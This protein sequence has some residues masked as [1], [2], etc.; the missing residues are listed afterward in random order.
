MLVTA[1]LTWQASAMSH[2]KPEEPTKLALDAIQEAK[3][4]FLANA[5]P[6]SSSRAAATILFDDLARAVTMGSLRGHSRNRHE[7][8]ELVEY[9]G[10]ASM[11]ARRLRDHMAYRLAT[12]KRSTQV[13]I[14]GPTAIDR[15][16]DRHSELY[17]RLEFVDT[18]TARPDVQK[19]ARR[20]R[21]FLCHASDDKAIVRG[22]SRDLVS[23]GFD[24][25]VDEDKLLPGHDWE[26]EIQR[27][28]R[29][30]DAV[31]ACLSQR[32]VTKS[33]FVQRELRLALNMADEKP[34]G[35]IFLIPVK[36]EPC[37]VPDRLQRWQ[38]VALYEDG[39]KDRLMQALTIS[40]A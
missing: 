30:S 31:L 28:I 13:V 15:G 9:P 22:L 32:S 3:D 11:F 21:V 1:A 26:L 4:R 6:R 25:W 14:K 38:W 10:N 16:D 5:R 19:S 34:E 39:A 8:A 12:D 20:I 29:E 27:A 24:V 18:A 17:L 35:R 33:G 23:A 40:G 7:L 36:I 2:G 37:E